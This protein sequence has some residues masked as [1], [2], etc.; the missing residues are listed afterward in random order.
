LN[1]SK[2]LLKRTLLVWEEWSQF[3]LEELLQERI[4]LRKAWTDN[5]LKRIIYD[6]M[7]NLLLL[8]K[9]GFSH[10]FIRPS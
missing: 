5:Q 9:N 6:I 3:S 4:K 8:Q 7:K 2:G 1:R 10:N